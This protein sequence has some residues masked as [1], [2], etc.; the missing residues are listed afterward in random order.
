[1]LCIVEV[2]AQQ[3]PRLLQGA[4]LEGGTSVA[5][6]PNANIRNT[7]TQQTTATNNLGLFEIRALVGDSLVVSKIGYTPLTHIVG[8]STNIL[9]RLYAD[10]VLIERVDILKK[11][12]EAELQDYFDGYRRQ[13]LHHGGNPS[14]MA[15]IFNPV[16][17]LY[18]RL[19]PS[20][21]NVRRF[22][23]LMNYELQAT[24]VDRAFNEYQVNKLT[25]LEAD[26]LVNFM[27]L[28]RPSYQQVESWANYD[29]QLYI[30]KSF[31]Q[32]EKNGRPAAPKLPKL[33]VPPQEK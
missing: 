31:E 3:P 22:K 33:H 2:V 9:I 20:G 14:L 8:D 32:F 24:A 28:Y 5:R 7:R 4:V 25:G 26:D 18:E 16:S 1:M 6:V 13:G 17:S 11:S 15:H 10:N 21:R 29:M 19:S 27:S 23:S 30:Q 12:R